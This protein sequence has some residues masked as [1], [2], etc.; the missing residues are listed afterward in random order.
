MTALDESTAAALALEQDFNAPPATVPMRGRISELDGVKRKLTDGGGPERQHAKGKL[1][2]RERVDL[3][4]DPDTFHEIEGLRRHRATGFGL[5]PKRPHGERR[6]DRLG[7]DLRAHGLRLR[8][9]LPCVRRFPRRAHASKI[10]KIMDLALA[11]GAPLI[12]INDGAGARIQEGVTA[13]AGHGVIFR[14]HVDGSWMTLRSKDT[15]LA[16]RKH[17]NQPA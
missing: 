2:V 17:G 15:P 11:A 16:F 3:L 14:R 6:G 1:T 8:A 7:D 4:L 9:R 10:H 12:S 13:L 5:D